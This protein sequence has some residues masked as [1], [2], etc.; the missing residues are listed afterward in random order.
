MM[1]EPYLPLGFSLLGLNL[2]LTLI[3]E[4]VG[5]IILSGPQFYICKVE[6]IITLIP[7]LT[8]RTDILPIK[9]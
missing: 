8:V 1:R 7:L 6:M 9:Y 2:G 3:T 5:Q 4:Q